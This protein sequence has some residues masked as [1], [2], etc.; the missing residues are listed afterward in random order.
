MI[1]KDERE[2]LYKHAEEKIKKVEELQ[3]LGL[4]CDDGDFVPTVHYPPITEYPDKGPEYLDDYV[5]PE[6]DLMDIYVH[7]PFCIQQCTY[8]HYPNKV[9]PCD[10]EKEKYIG[11]LIREMDLFLNKFGKEKIR[12]R[13]ILLGGGTPT[14]L[15]PALLDR[16]LTEFDKRVDFSKCKQHNVDLGPNSI[17]GEFGTEKMQILKDHGVTRLT[18]GL[19]SLDDRVLKLMNRPHDSK[20]AIDS[21]YKALEF[22]FD[23]NI[24]FIFGHP[25]ETIDNWTDVM[26]R[27]IELPM[28]EIQIYRLKVQAYGDRQG[29]IN[30]RKRGSGEDDI[31]DFKNT[32]MM[33][34]IAEEMMENHG[35]NE[36]LRRVF[37]KDK[38][39][40]SHYAYNQC[41]AQYDQVGFGLSGFS[42]Y[43]DRFDINSYNFDEYYSMIDEGRLPITRAYKHSVEEKIR[44]KIVLPLKNTEIIK[45]RFTKNSG[46][47]NIDDLFK[48]K[49]A[50]LKG[51]GLLEDNGKDIHLTKD[52]GRFVADEVC[53]CFNSDEHK[54]FP[55]ERYAEGPLNPYN[56]NV[57][58]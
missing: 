32:M 53:E 34:S 7:I 4:I 58:F 26:A 29:V 39:I 36:T 33:K 44:Q 25:G 50:T 20:W 54:P 22:G 19:Q 24:E 55:R 42:S 45:T 21:V 47:Y 14:N 49:I 15:K 3:R 17:V 13:S 38:K 48:K 11:Y 10:D 9:G 51:Y 18:I 12:P 56:D 27:A 43:R 40:F 28:N 16:F 35:F 52:L 23:V 31:P 46:G 37:S 41:C 57:V 1:S 2:L 30:R 8:C 5:W 6:D